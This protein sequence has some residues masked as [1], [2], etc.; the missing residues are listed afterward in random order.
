MA[1]NKEE[2]VKKFKIDFNELRSKY[3][4][5]TQ[6]PTSF[7]NQNQTQ[8]NNNPFNSAIITT[9]K[10]QNFESKET[11]TFFDKINKINKKE[12][13]SS[14]LHSKTVIFSK[15]EKLQ[16][17]PS[18][19]ISNEI[20]Q[21]NNN[22]TKPISIKTESSKEIQN[23]E[24]NE[25][26][27]FNIS[28]KIEEKLNELKEFNNKSLNSISQNDSEQKKQINIEENSIKNIN[29][30]CFTNNCPKKLNLDEIF[31]NMKISQ[32]SSNLKKEKQV[33]IMKSAEARKNK[34]DEERLE[35]QKEECENEDLN[36]NSKNKPVEEF[37]IYQE[38]DDLY[39]QC[40]ENEN[41]FDKPIEENYLTNDNETHPMSPN[42]IKSNLKKI[43]EKRFTLSQIPINNKNDNINVS[44]GEKKINDIKEQEKNNYSE[45]KDD[46]KALCNITEDDYF[47][48]FKSND[49]NEKKEGP[50]DKK[51]FRSTI[52]KIGRKLTLTEKK[53]PKHYLNS[54]KNIPNSKINKIEEIFLENREILSD[55]KNIENT[56]CESFFLASYPEKDGKIIEN[57]ENICADCK[58]EICSILSAM[59]PEI[60]YKYPEKNIH[61]LELSNLA[62]SICFPNGIK[63]CYEEKED[64]IEI[65]KNYRT[66]L[67]N[68][69]GD[70]YFVM[71]FHFFY[72]MLNDDFLKKYTINSLN[73]TLMAY[74]EKLY[75]TFN[76]VKIDDTSQQ[77]I[78]SDLKKFSEIIYRE[79][80]Y[81][82]FCLCLISK[83]PFY[84]EME[85]CLGSILISLNSDD[86]A[87]P[88]IN[89]FITYIIKSIPGPTQNIKLHIP[90]LNCNH[91]LELTYPFFED[92]CLFGVNPVVLIKYLPINQ[93]ILLFRLL[94]F[95]QKILIVGENYDIV[96]Q[97]ILASI[98]L[99]YPFQWIHT[100]IPIMSEKMI[101]Y[102][103]AFLP[104]FNGMNTSLYE[105]SKK[106]LMKADEG[107][108]IFDLDNHTVDVNTNL[109]KKSAILKN[110]LYIHKHLPKFP[111]NIENALSKELELIKSFFNG[112]KNH[113]Y[114]YEVLLKTNIYIRNLFLHIFVEL[115]YD[116]D[117][118]LN[119]ID[120]FPVFNT[121]MMLNQKP[122]NDNVFYK[123]I[124]S[125]QLFQMFIQKC[126]SFKEDSSEK[127]YFHERI[128][129]YLNFK[130][131]KNISNNTQKLFNCSL[132]NFENKFIKNLEIEKNYIIKPNF[133]KNFENF[134][135]KFTKKKLKLK[136]IN[137]FLSKQFD[138]IYTQYYLKTNGIFKTTKRILNK[139][140]NF[141]HE[142]DP[143]KIKNYIYP[144]EKIDILKSS[145]NN[146]IFNNFNEKKRI[147]SKV[148][149]ITAL[150]GRTTSDGSCFSYVRNKECDLTE[151]EIDEIK[152]NI[153]EAMTRVFKSQIT[154]IEDDKK[155]IMSSVEKS[156]GRDYFINVIL[157]SKKIDKNVQ[158]FNETS[159]NLLS[160]IIKN[161]LLNILY[162]EENKENLM[163]AVKLFKA[164]L[165]IKTIKKGKELFLSDDL[166]F[167]MDDYPLIQ[168]EIFWEYW[169]ESEL[170]EENNKLLRSIKEKIKNKQLYEFP[171][172]DINYQNY[173]DRFSEIL[174]GL[175]GIM[176]KFKLKSDD[177]FTLITE[178][179]HNYIKEKR[180]GQLIQNLIEQLYFYKMH[181]ENLTSKNKDLNKNVTKD[182]N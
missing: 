22:I 87:P 110:R 170:S 71:T 149:I 48:K 155:L 119:Y 178:L 176:I 167:K 74:T 147:S 134:E 58:H 131:D 138:K 54:E 106:I 29:N 145:K 140:L 86:L 13:E 114:N 139:T 75:S 172:N 181:Y 85:K 180:R 15:K 135:S 66:T 70:R 40:E 98:S 171:E 165:Y 21:K 84:K 24:N 16:R 61:G 129:E 175:V 182:D 107:V 2:K 156:F 88:Q 30:Y 137:D 159:Y 150:D 102:L 59:Q 3:N 95:E 97:I 136:D 162:L 146:S 72:K 51:S 169:V 82:P 57:S 130:K 6:K 101:K 141:S 53:L 163:C 56:F 39:E 33:E 100:S 108:F 19:A 89:E 73:N 38:E 96:S 32:I 68:Q 125:T 120:D 52:Q 91:L 37:N 164:C 77:E 11:N 142:N 99:L 8:N 173:E 45:K 81:V 7:K 148:R 26:T 5:I 113:N 49:P 34:E 4:T 115:F 83:Y 128:K 79:N 117:E 93:I 17:F 43:L 14:I 55:D 28:K 118:Y 174:D 133:I 18:Q 35:I 179:S 46:S 151:D 153:R 132:E 36:N 154:N 103:Q 109:K 166:F 80:V 161:S 160:L 42:D 67:T 105:R 122:K 10:K 92:I 44:V 112:E 41:D 47:E 62:A 12:E 116:Y 157:P 23:N 124:T 78:Q 1:E 50:E 94:L 31:K 90:L 20:I 76:D 123:E 143:K 25:N 152:E 127:F 126:L 104:F 111:K 60:I 144:E 69:K 65:M 177:I 27:R 158:L 63:N 9:K 121:F 64:K 168:K